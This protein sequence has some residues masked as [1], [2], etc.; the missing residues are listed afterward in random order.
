MVD[1]LT[2]DEDGAVGC[3]VAD[4]DEERTSPKPQTVRLAAASSAEARKGT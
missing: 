4:R 2:R 3:G 1:D